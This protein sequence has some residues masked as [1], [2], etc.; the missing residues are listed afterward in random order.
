MGTDWFAL[1]GLSIIAIYLLVLIVFRWQ[2][3]KLWAHAPSIVILGFF[4]LFVLQLFLKKKKESFFFEVSP[5]RDKCLREQVSRHDYDRERTCGCCGKGTVGGIP[6][7]YAEWL[8]VDPDTGDRW[9]RPDN[10]QW[11]DTFSNAEEAVC[12]PFTSPSYIKFL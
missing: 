11:V 1:S 9:H 5:S 2:K 10:V 6:P 7:N 8:D 3:K 12:T 4:I